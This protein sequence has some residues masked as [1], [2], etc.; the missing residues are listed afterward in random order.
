MSIT[1]AVTRYITQKL[2]TTVV[3]T[4]DE[5]SIILP[6][7]KLWLNAQGGNSMTKPGNRISAW[8][9]ESGNDNHALQPTSTQQPLFVPGIINGRDGVIFTNTG[10]TKLI[11][12]S[13]NYSASGDATIFAVVYTPNANGGVARQLFNSNI[14]PN[15]SL[16]HDTPVQDLSVNSFNGAVLTK[17]SSAGSNLGQTNVIMGRVNGTGN[18]ELELS[19]Q[20]QSVAPM[21]TPLATGLSSP[22][23]GNHPSSNSEFNNY[24]GELIVYDRLLDPSELDFVT[25][26]LINRWGI[27]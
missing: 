1:R 18:M 5:P 22:S 25:G 3:Q 15:L 11:A 24:L 19:G 27:S 6:G 9:D 12:G 14:I 4:P 7:I 17:A 23:I 21:P 20:P 2:T 8:N 26:V 16:N 10:L 13:D